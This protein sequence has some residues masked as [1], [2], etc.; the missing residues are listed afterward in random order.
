MCSRPCWVCSACDVIS[1]GP[2]FGAGGDGGGGGRLVGMESLYRVPGEHH[3][4]SHYTAVASWTREASGDGHCHC[5]CTGETVV[6]CI[7]LC[8]LTAAAT[9]GTAPL[10]TAGVDAFYGG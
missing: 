8:P 2:G 4:V 6:R 1:A 5:R 7:V 3:H 9:G 10:M